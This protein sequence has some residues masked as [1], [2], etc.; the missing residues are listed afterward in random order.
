MGEQVLSN[1]PP[2]DH[3]NRRLLIREV[4]GEAPLVSLLEHLCTDS[5][6]VLK[7]D[8]DRGLDTNRWINGGFVWDA[9][10]LQGHIHGTSTAEP[11]ED[12][13]HTGLSLTSQVFGW[14]PGKRAVAMIRL[15]LGGLSGIVEFGF[16][17]QLVEQVSGGVVLAKSTPLGA[18]A[19]QDYAIA[20][21]DP[22]DNAFFGIVSLGRDNTI[23]GGTNSKTVA[24]AGTDFTLM[25]ALNEQTESRLWVDGMPTDIEYSGPSRYADLGV[26][27]H[28]DTTS[29]NVDYVQI[30]QERDTV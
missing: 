7:D 13:P 29:I 23:G 17:D 10:D 18:G 14:S 24:I 28:A 19:P 3:L 6:Y 15:R 4:G 25:L 30:W 9:E 1:I 16:V 22:N 12:R 27:L 26:W 2:N 11:G 8:F 21:R 20:V 5:V